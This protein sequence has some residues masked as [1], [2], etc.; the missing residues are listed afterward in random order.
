ME[1]YAADAARY[2]AAGDPA[3][4]AHVTATAAA[5]AAAGRKVH[6][7]DSPAGLAERARQAAWLVEH[8]AL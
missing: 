4:A 8:L 1:G 5:D 2:A 6:E 3:V 7:Q